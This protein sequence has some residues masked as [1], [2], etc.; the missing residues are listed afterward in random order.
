MACHWVMDY[1]FADSGSC[2]CADERIANACPIHLCL[3]PPYQAFLFVLAGIAIGRLT[4]GWSV[5]DYYTTPAL[6]ILRYLGSANV[7][8]LGLLAAVFASAFGEALADMFLDRFRTNPQY[9]M[10][11]R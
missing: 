3:D 1:A 11:A 5:V 6:T 10:Y 8:V 2:E 4:P 9:T 7:Y